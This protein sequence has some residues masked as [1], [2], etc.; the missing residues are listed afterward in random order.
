MPP[1]TDK[2]AT[3]GKTPVLLTVLIETGKFRWYVAGVGL[4]GIAFPLVCSEEGNLT[5]Y[6]GVSPDEQLSFLR[7]RLSGVLQ[8]GCDRLWGRQMK[9]C[10]IVFIADGSLAQA[11]PDLFRNVG[12]HFVAWM[13]KP[14]IAAF[15]SRQGFLASEPV[16]LDLVAGAID[17]A[18]YQALVAGLPRL[19]TATQQREVWEIPPA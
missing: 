13:A 11:S 4:D 9:P 6:L 16:T 10:Q 8:R 14:P 17:P 3:A 12:E 1:E 18:Y 5:P 7:H 19:F 15:T 2:P